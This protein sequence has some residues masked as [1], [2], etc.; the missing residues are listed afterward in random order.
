[1]R[2]DLALKIIGMLCPQYDPG[3]GAESTN[4]KFSSITGGSMHE[5]TKPERPLEVTAALCLLYLGLVFAVIAD[6]MGFALPGGNT[7]DGL[8]MLVFL[9]ISVLIYYMIGEGKNWA[10]ITFFVLL[11][12][13]ILGLVHHFVDKPLDATW[14]A[15]AKD[16]LLIAEAGVDLMA[17]VMLFLPVSSEWFKAVDKTREVRLKRTIAAPLGPDETLWKRVIALLRNTDQPIRSYIWQAWLIAIIPA[18][19]IS[20]VVGL[21]M[22]EDMPLTREPPVVI[23]VSA[24]V[25]A[26]WLE[27][28]LMVPIL[29]ILKLTVRKTLWVAGVSAV[30][31][32]I[33]HSTEAVT[34]GFAVA[35]PFFVF[36]LCYLEW[37][38]KST[39]TA[40]GVTAILHA[41]HNMVP[42]LFLVLGIWFG[43]VPPQQEVNRLTPG[44][45]HIGATIL[46]GKRLPLASVPL[47]TNLFEG[48][49]S[50]SEED[51]SSEMG[52]LNN[53][54]SI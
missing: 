7:S 44:P 48:V 22:P 10:R 47:Y 24:L 46:D 1:M 18:T 14:S 38:S 53:N 45:G 15:R 32:G 33:L 11:V 39:L 35:W 13:S 31:W 51:R 27:T 5:N 49:D 6:A 26:P 2:S 54:G 8:A 16:C 21:I 4:M 52:Q 42:T 28:F 19:V 17:L 40:I 50:L 36:S 29:W 41:C 25:I 37:Q 9:P 12:L 23:A 20:I 3:N 30:L 43:E 34:W